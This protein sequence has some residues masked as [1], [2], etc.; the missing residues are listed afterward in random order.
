MK[1]LLPHKVPGSVVS[2]DEPRRARLNG[3]KVRTYTHRSPPARTLCGTIS[4]SR[5]EP[6]RHRLPNTIRICR[7]GGQMVCQQCRDAA[8]PV[9]SP[10]LAEGR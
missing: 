7:L 1:N 4:S 3:W 5:A 8:R 10:T 2:Q 6:G 9:Q